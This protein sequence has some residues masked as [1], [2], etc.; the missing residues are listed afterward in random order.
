[1]KFSTL[2]LLIVL[3]TIRVF[4]LPSDSILGD[5]LFFDEKFEKK[6]EI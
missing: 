6:H 1:M 2:L 4:L 5:V 3:Y